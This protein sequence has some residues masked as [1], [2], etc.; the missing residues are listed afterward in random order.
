M[1]RFVLF[2]RGSEE[3]PMANK[4]PNS[5]RKEFTARLLPD[6]TALKWTIAPIPF[7]VA[8]VWPG[9][10]GRRVRGEIDGFAFRTTLVS[11]PRGEGA[12]L[13]VNRKMQAATHARIGDKVRIWLEPD[14]EEREIKLPRE[15]E[16]ELN[17]DRR[18]RKLFDGMSDARRR[19]FGKFADT[20]KSAASREKRAAKIAE[21]LMQAMEGEKDPPPV[22]RA[23][24]QRTP[25]AYES[26][27]ALTPIQ[28]RNHLYGIFYYETPEARERRAQKAIDEAMRKAGNRE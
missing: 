22:L 17:S 6:G 12:V 14:T 11:Y 8:K 27:N 20:P 4:R 13:I 25:G 5:E 16:R 10:N 9:R 1:R 18:L 3:R 19:E 28:R 2:L 23:L 21:M 7:D 26:W 24:F 15:L